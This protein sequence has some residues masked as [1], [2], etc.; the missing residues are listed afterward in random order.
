MVRSKKVESENCAR[1]F[2]GDASDFAAFLSAF[3]YCLTK[4]EIYAFGK[5]A[6]EAIR[7]G[8]DSTSRINRIVLLLPIFS[9]DS[10]KHSADLEIL[11]KRGIEIITFLYEK[12]KDCTRTNE[13]FS[14]Y[15]IVYIVKNKSL[16]CGGL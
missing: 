10:T 4:Y 14:K 2:G 13:L 15:G 8:I 5:G 6:K 9:I 11:Q 3:G 7:F 12:D 1:F 16:F